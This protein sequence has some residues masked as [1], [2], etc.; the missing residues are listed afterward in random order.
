MPATLRSI[1]PAIQ[2]RHQLLPVRI[3]LLLATVQVAS[4]MKMGGPGSINPTRLRGGKHNTTS[5]AT[6]AKVVHRRL[7]SSSLQVVDASSQE[8]AKLEKAYDSTMED[9]LKFQDSAEALETAEAF[10]ETFRVTSYATHDLSKRAV[11]HKD[12]VQAPMVHNTSVR[13]SSLMV[14]DAD[15]QELTDH[16][17]NKAIFLGDPAI[18]LLTNSPPSEQAPST[19]DGQLPSSPTSSGG[20]SLVD[21]HKLEEAYNSTMQEALL[22]QISEE[23]QRLTQDRLPAPSSSTE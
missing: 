22:F 15:D 19:A 18:D 4:S 6:T 1:M 21:L 23:G 16:I 3:I 20:S 12:S 9:A 7:Q 11:S 14:E 13:S 10:E 2:R 5:P 17:A 8:S